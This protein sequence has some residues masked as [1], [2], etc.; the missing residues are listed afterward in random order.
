MLFLTL[1]DHSHNNFDNK[2]NSLH[3][4]SFIMNKVYK[5]EEPCVG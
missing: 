5:V 4:Q 3:K 2:L 1:Y